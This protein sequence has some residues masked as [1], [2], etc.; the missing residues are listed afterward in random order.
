MNTTEERLHDALRAAGETIEAVPAF[1]VPARR[2]TLRR[3]AA[4]VSVAAVV[5]AGVAFWSGSGGKEPLSSPALASLVE[6]GEISVFLCLGRS[7]SNPACGHRDATVAEKAAIQQKIMSLPQVNAVEYESKEKAFVRF[8]HAFRNKPG[9][10]S[11]TKVG[12]IPDS[13]RLRLRNQ[14]LSQPVT[15][16]ITG[17]PGVDQIVDETRQRHN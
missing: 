12:D 8:M 16:A 14:G 17:M 6:P 7:T 11:A 3:I 9:L 15:A 5:I 2:F 13:F 4:F 10:V 1:V